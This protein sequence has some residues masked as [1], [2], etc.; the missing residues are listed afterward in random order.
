MTKFYFEKRPEKGQ[1]TKWRFW[2]VME[3]EL[4][5]RVWN[6][7]VG[8]VWQDSSF[9]DV[10]V[11]HF[12]VKCCFVQLCFLCSCP[13]CHLLRLLP[14]LPSFW[15]CWYCVKLLYQHIATVCMIMTI[16]EQY[17]INHFHRWNWNIEG[18]NLL[19][20]LVA[21]SSQKEKDQ[22]QCTQLLALALQKF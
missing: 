3:P 11:H 8:G 17:L 18:F 10:Q 13:V 6:S 2:N 9:R 21:E 15:F 20:R 16:S 22:Q 7:R 14:L 1:K 4:L 19:C 5:I 12:K